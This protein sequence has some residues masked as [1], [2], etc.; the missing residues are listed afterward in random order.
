MMGPMAG[1]V[2]VVVPGLEVGRGVVVLESK[3]TQQGSV[4]KG[5]MVHTSLARSS[6]RKPFLSNDYKQIK[7][8]VSRC[9]ACST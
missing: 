3:L 5:A 7:V 8:R 6:L 4:E 9:V 2:G 1:P